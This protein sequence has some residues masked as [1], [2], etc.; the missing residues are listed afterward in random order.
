MFDQPRPSMN[1]RAIIRDM[2][3]EE[4]DL[5][6]ALGQGFLSDRLGEVEAKLARWQRY[7]E[8]HYADSAPPRGDA[9]KLHAYQVELVLV[10][11][12]AAAAQSEP[13]PAVHQHALDSA[14]RRAQR[15]RNQRD[16]ANPALRRIRHD[17]RLEQ[18]LLLELWSKWHTW[19]TPRQSQH[20]K[21]GHR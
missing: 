16:F 13:F 15:Y 8:N 5:L 1:I 20:V 9:D 14:R 17:A 2:L 7:L 6:I 11:S 21:P 12:L 19:I 18:E 3:D 10:R 4:R